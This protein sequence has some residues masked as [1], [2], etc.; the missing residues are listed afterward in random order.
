VVRANCR[1]RLRF[2]LDAELSGPPKQNLIATPEFADPAGSFLV[3]QIERKVLVGS[4]K[5]LDARSVA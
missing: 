3:G 4:L 1:A 2:P 5:I